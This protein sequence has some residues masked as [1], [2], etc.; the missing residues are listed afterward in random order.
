[1]GFLNDD[2]FRPRIAKV[3]DV[4]ALRPGE[5]GSG[6]SII[7]LSAKDVD[8]AVGSVSKGIVVIGLSL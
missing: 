2:L 3:S 7:D 8:I 4:K 1:M 6:G 5:G